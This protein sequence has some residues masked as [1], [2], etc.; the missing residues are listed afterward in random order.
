ML[1]LAQR[2]AH[3][4]LTRMCFIDY[5]REMAFVADRRDPTTGDHA[6]FGVSRLT[7]LHGTNDAEF[8]VVVADERQHRGLGTELLSRVIEFGRDEKMDRITAD[9]LSENRAMLRVCEELGFALDF[10]ADPQVVHAVFAVTSGT[11]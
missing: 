8:A 4:R 5:D 1:K 11:V 6:I 2:V 10:G 7:R 9:I 3:E